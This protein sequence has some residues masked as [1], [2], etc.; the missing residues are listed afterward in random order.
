[1]WIGNSQFTSDYATTSYDLKLETAK[2][3][4][5]W[6]I[7]YLVKAA[8]LALSWAIFKV[9]P[10]FRKA[11]WIVTTYTFLTFWPVFL[12]QLWSCGP[13]SDYADLVACD[14]FHNPRQWVELAAMCAALHGSSELAILALP[15][16]YIRKLNMSKSQKVSAGGMFAVAIINIVMGFMRN[17]GVMCYYLG[18]NKHGSNDLQY[19]MTIYEPTLAVIVC[20]LPPY[21]AVLSKFQKQRVT[22]HE[23]GRDVEKAGTAAPHIGLSVFTFE[24]F[25]STA[26]LERS[27]MF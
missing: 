1:M 13:P 15:L 25:D 5:L 10:S 4:L 19:I 6:M 7:L 24:T 8:F 27:E 11:W 17:F 2:G 22:P 16:I 12:K 23:L 26:A 18:F 9:S 21:Q 3:L 14:N 20:A